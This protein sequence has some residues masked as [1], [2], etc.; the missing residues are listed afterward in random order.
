SPTS[1]RGGGGRGG[2]NTPRA[3]EPNS[4]RGRRNQ[5]IDAEF[6]PGGARAIGREP[7][8]ARGRR[9]QEVDAP[10]APL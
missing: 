8:S 2:R 10:F 1:G 4:G 3:R 6:A 5:D 9:N 7:S